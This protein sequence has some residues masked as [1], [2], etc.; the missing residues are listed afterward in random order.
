MPVKYLY[1]SCRFPRIYEVLNV[2]YTRPYT[3]HIRDYT[4]RI[5]ETTHVAYTRLGTTD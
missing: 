3:S 1:I 5:Y 4:R 2:A